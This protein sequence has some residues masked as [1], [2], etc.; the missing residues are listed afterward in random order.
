MKRNTC[1]TLV[2]IVP[3]DPEPKADLLRGRL[4]RD[5]TT[6]FGDDSYR[7]GVAN[8]RHRLQARTHFLA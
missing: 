5:N 4:E 8:Q 6:V 2:T 1:F 3:V 7:K